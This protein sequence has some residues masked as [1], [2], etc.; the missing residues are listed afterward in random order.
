MYSLLRY[1]QRLPLALPLL[2]IAFVSTSVSLAKKEHSSTFTSPLLYQQTATPWYQSTAISPSNMTITQTPP[3]QEGQLFFPAET[4]P[5][6]ATI[7]GF[8]SPHSVPRELLRATRNEILDLA[9]TISE[10]EPV[11]VYVRAGDEGLA[12]EI[13]VKRHARLVDMY[14]TTGDGKGKNKNKN[15]KKKGKVDDGEGIPQYNLN[16]VTFHTCPTNHPWVR[17]TG[18]VYVLDT[19]N[20]GKR[21]A[22]DFGFCEWGGKNHG[23]IDVRDE[24]VLQEYKDARDERAPINRTGYEIP[25]KRH[26]ENSRF[27][28]QVL[29][30]EAHGY[31]NT[32]TA[33]TTTATTNK[34]N[35]HIERITSP[36]RLEGGGIE[37]DGNG[38]L[39]ATESSILCRYRN[40]DMPKA[41]I[42]MHLRR[43]LGV[44][45]IIWFP[46]RRDHDITDCHV[47]GEVKFLAPGL[48]VLSKPHKRAEKVEKEIYREIRDILTRETDAQGRKFKIV[49]LE[50]PDLEKVGWSDDDYAYEQAYEEGFDEE[51][52]E[53][54]DVAGTYVNFYFVNGGLILPAFGDKRQDRRAVETL[55]KWIEPERKIRQVYSSA[56]PRMGGVVHCVTQQVV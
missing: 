48:V 42:E 52:E 31:N 14:S 20:P 53:D 19:T 9:V 50:G 49:E 35:Q 44:S 32:T 26:W 36:V 16:N 28:K 46:G 18:P 43:L 55:R 45:K 37:V 38:T 1:T 30:V 33:N 2:S 29:E 8:P 25:D 41:T 11:R 54:E 7:L 5:H 51:D 56:L 23:E 47:D 27:A 40:D 21:V 6:L 15:N 13:L 12:R 34:T 17:D 39:L 3:I 4:A 10:F 24:L 22:I